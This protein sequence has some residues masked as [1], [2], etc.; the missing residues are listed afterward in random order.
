MKGEGFLRAIR[1]GDWAVVAGAAFA[2]A[3]S[4]PLLWSGGAAERAV[5]RSAGRVVAELPLGRDRTLA[6][7]G[8]LGESVV[9][10]QGGRARVESDPGPRQYCVRQG[11]LDRAGD[12][13]LCLPNQVSVELVGR[14]RPYDSLS[15]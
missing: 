15:Y 11:W 14:S 1:P 10:V 7:A 6:V 8:P 12:T 3:A 9:R 2:V 5:V 13:A 4:F